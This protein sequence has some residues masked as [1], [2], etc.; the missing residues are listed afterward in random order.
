M[1]LRTKILVWFL[2]LSV[3]PLAAIVSYSYVS[4]TRALR[5]AVLT[6]TWELAN[7]LQTQMES[8]REELTGRVQ[9]LN[10]LP[11]D[12]FFAES[13]S[14]GRGAFSEEYET[15]I[16]DIAPFIDSLEFVP[17][18]PPAPRAAATL[19]IAPAAPEPA[20]VPDP[21]KEP[22]LGFEPVVI[23]IEHLTSMGDDQLVAAWKTND[24]LADWGDFAKV[25]G[26]VDAATGALEAMRR[27]LEKED[28]TFERRARLEA[29]GEHLSVI[30]EFAV[31][32]V[33]AMEEGELARRAKRTKETQRVLGQDIVCPV[34][35]AGEEVGNLR[36]SV[37]TSRVMAEVLGRTDRSQ[38]EIPFAFDA[39]G[40]VYLA[41]AEDQEPLEAIGMIVDGRLA[42]NQDVDGW[43]V[44]YLADEDSDLTF[45]IARPI[46]D[47]V[48]ELRATAGRNFGL[49][50]GLVG[51][52]LI[53]VLPLS[54]RLTRDLE[55]L[56]EGS[57]RLAAG[58][59]DARVAVRSRD[60]VGKLAQSFNGLA[61][62]LEKNQ[63]RL[64]RTQVQ[65]ELLEAEN[66]RKTSELEEARQFQISL[67]PKDLPDHP[68][69]EIA[70]FMRTATEVGGDYYDFQHAADGTLTTVIGD[71]TGH[72][73]RAGTMVTVIKSLF[74][75]WPGRGP[76]ADFLAEAA[77][78]IKNMHLGRMAMA[79]S[80]VRISGDTLQV[81]SAGMPPV[82][83]C[84]GDRKV[85]EIALSGLPLGGMAFSR[86]E[87]RSVKLEVGDTVLLMSDGFP[88]LPNAD[89]EPI[90]YDRVRRLFEAS[91]GKSPQEVI[92]SLAQ[93]ASE[94]HPE[95]APAD[96]IT[97][98]ALRVR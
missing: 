94:W 17:S 88:E 68:G 61:R 64:L 27:V 70:V 53:G 18:I 91:C 79:L 30:R 57:E 86:Y 42:E 60:E 33:S 16:Q 97:F 35:V 89:G 9:E 67:L 50:F 65:R 15:L 76:L 22:A 54:R 11:W 38:D 23:E 40:R 48:R 41:Q 7:G 95:V 24:V 19:G 12:E 72:G 85:E 52:A 56:T 2:L 29:M 26:G 93:H 63:K 47:S 43:V 62:E 84:R 39:D 55:E 34:E 3:L 36:A 32:K 59:W 87:A 58:N 71:A 44:A 8:T 66:E 37:L 75:A 28:L 96:D 69:L 49:G 98:V 21:D 73:A 20:P 25:P 90:G 78:S 10:D 51:L 1:S 83:I 46:R 92:D 81:S 80:L 4:S 13:W 45:A 14:D 74:T 5:Q 31:R 82:L 6:E 77:T